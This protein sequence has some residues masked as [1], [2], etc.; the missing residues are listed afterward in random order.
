MSLR[1]QRVPFR[2]YAEVPSR[3][4]TRF[5]DT[6]AKPAYWPASVPSELSNTSST[7]AVP[8]GLR[9]LE[10]LN[11]TSA[12]ESPRKCFAEISPMTQRTA[13]MMFDLPQPFGPTTPRKIAGK[14]D[15]G[16]INERLETGQFDFVESHRAPGESAAA[17][18]QTSSLSLI[19]RVEQRGRRRTVGA[20]PPSCLA[21]G[22]PARH[23]EAL[24]GGL[25][26][27]NES[28]LAASKSTRTEAVLALDSSA[29]SGRFPPTSLC[30]RWP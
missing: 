12:I 20:R 23:F 27:G 29:Q 28:L 24:I 1:R 25:V 22:Q 11:T 18:G 26:Y 21:L 15:G 7:D 16:R 14:I 2:K 6:S 30:G 17:W 4:T 3:D 5:S 19:E 9:E 10:P 13:S 8:T